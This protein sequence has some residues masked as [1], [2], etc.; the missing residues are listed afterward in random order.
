[1]RYIASFSLSSCNKAA[2]HTP[3]IT[4]IWPGT[5]PCHF[6]THFT[7]GLDDPGLESE[8]GPDNFFS[9]KTCRQ[10][11]GPTLI[12]SQWAPYL[13]VW[14]VERTGREVDHSPSPSAEVTQEKWYVVFCWCCDTVLHFHS[15]S[16]LTQQKICRNNNNTSHYTRI[17]N[18]IW[19]IA[20]TT[21]ERPRTHTAI[22]S[23]LISQLSE[24]RSP[25]YYSVTHIRSKLAIFTHYTDLTL[26]DNSDGGRGT[27]L[28]CNIKGYIIIIIIISIS[29]S[30]SSSS[31]RRRRRRRRR[32]RSSRSSSNCSFS[33][34]LRKAESFRSEQCLN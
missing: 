15:P 24:Q 33:N 2:L 1:M 9:F 23:N 29:S 3:G 21:Y 6:I 4:Q 25:Q 16:S 27:Q 26:G 7:T 34:S 11:L 30:S 17:N 14:W 31:S 10:S 18:N 28:T 12:P 22:G 13:S 20:G 8:Q 32:R 5:C 19:Q